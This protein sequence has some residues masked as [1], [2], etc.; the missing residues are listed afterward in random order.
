[1]RR[2]RLRSLLLAVVA[3]AVVPMAVLVLV[4]ARAELHDAERSQLQV[5]AGYARLAADEQA[6]LIDATRHVMLTLAQ[7]PAVR[8]P[9]LHALCTDYLAR[10]SAQLPG[11]SAL[12]LADPDGRVR[13][14]S[15]GR[16]G[17]SLGDR[18]YFGPA[19]R[20]DAFVYGGLVQ[21]RQSG[22]QAL[23]FA[24]PV[25]DAA[26]S[27]NGVLA[28]G[29]EL[30]GLQR[31]E[32]RA[33]LPGW[34]HLRLVDAQGR[35][36]GTLAGPPDAS[37]G[38][39]L[40]RHAL[41]EALAV[42]QPSALADADGGTRWWHALQP[43]AAGQDRLWVVASVPQ[44]QLQAPMLQRLAW[45][46]GGFAAVLLLA[47]VLAWLV[48][49]RWVTAPAERLRRRIQQRMSGLPAPPEPQHSLELAE[50]D[51]AVTAFDLKL[52]ERERRLQGQLRRLQL[53]HRITHAAGA[54]LDTASIEA[55]V[56]EYVERHLPA[57]ACAFATR[58]PDTGVLVLGT[59]GPRAT[60]LLPA[61]GL[62][63]GAHLLVGENGIACCLQGETVCENELGRRDAP[64]ARQLAAAGFRCLSLAPLPGVDDSVAGVLL[65]ARRE[66]PLESGDCEFLAQLAQHVALATRQATL[67]ARLRQSYDELRGTQ[68]RL[69]EQ[70][71]LRAVGQMAAG[72][73]HDINNSLAPALLHADALAE[74][75]S[76]LAERERGQLDAIRRGIEGVAATVSRLRDLYRP[77]GAD[78]FV[79]LD[80]NELLQQVA[81][82]TRTRWRDQAQRDGIHIEL[83]LQPAAALP[84]LQAVRAELRDALVN[85]VFNAVDAMPGGGVLT[86]AS[87]DAE[88]P[89]GRAAL[90]LSVHDS[91]TGMDEATRARCLDPFFS[92]KGE[93]GTGLGLPMVALTAE[94]HGGRLEIASA[95]GQG[96]CFALLLPL[97]QPAPAPA[98]QPDLTLGAP[99]VGPLRL[100]VV[101]DEVAVR[102]ALASM[103]RID[104]HEVIEASHGRQALAL[105]G[106]AIAMDRPPHAVLSD[107]GMPDL[108]G[109][110]LALAVKALRRSLPVL[111][112]TGWGRGLGETA[113]P[114]GVDLLLTKPVRWVELRAALAQLC[115]PADD[116]PPAA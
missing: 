52:E 70:E 23:A 48:G 100:L 110:Q 11:Y 9:T 103:L 25:R 22:R 116:Q 108:D 96:A 72:I 81:E 29:L 3:A 93:R 4:R 31:P 53:L 24:V 76:A 115:A 14:A 63:R 74:H 104:G 27:V 84:L 17:Q 56:V 13:C 21:G 89:D 65:A 18:P 51:A 49:T 62:G 37:P 73:A 59:C 88:L 12:A 55:V 8:D 1:M 40:P 44:Q 114:P 61:A 111:M 101:D 105:L 97:R 2:L 64:L 35:L 109:R 26:G 20:G 45:Q 5:L 19:L 41:H 78:S 102:E 30:G 112:I 47:G 38:E 87:A 107:L 16:S 99:P 39:A 54:R 36:L 66:S 6:R 32:A 77:A 50:I 86:L 15:T 67:H 113:L 75:D 7:G 71:R 94:R 83:R 69:L 80:A 82:V 57:D 95:P 91:G 106:E 85:L 98:P 43:L 90:R 46:L 58:E 60:A 34:L 79:A 42:G 28:A 92:S 68:Q 10:I 33:G